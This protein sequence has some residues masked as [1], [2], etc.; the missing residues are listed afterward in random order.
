[1]SS[2]IPTI[3]F[4]D[5]DPNPELYKG[6]IEQLFAIYN[7]KKQAI[8]SEVKKMHPGWFKSDVRKNAGYKL[9]GKY[10]KE[11][12]NNLKEFFNTDI[13]NQQI[14]NLYKDYLNYAEKKLEILKGF[15]KNPTDIKHVEVKEKTVMVE[16]NRGMGHYAIVP[17]IHIT[18]EYFYLELTQPIYIIESPLLLYVYTEELTPQIIEKLYYIMEDW[19]IFKFTGIGNYSKSELKQIEIIEVGKNAPITGLEQLSNSLYAY[20]KYIKSTTDVID[21]RYKNIVQGEKNT[22]KRNKCMAY[23]KQKDD[24]I[25]I[26]KGKIETYKVRRQQLREFRQEIIDSKPLVQQK[27][28]ELDDKYTSECNEIGHTEG[29]RRKTRRRHRIQKKTLRRH[30]K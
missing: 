23:K 18:P 13:G 27:I 21:K 2:T 14:S 25:A 19:L 20:L 17:S 10:L 26:Y 11:L 29:G 28:K 5:W 3:D 7:Q 9:E 16:E 30:R 24:D 22:D 1:M 12:R 8:P 6:N 15:L 4:S